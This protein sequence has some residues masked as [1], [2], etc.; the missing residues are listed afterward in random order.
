MT[1][2]F[3]ER[4]RVQRGDHQTRAT[5]WKLSQE[6]ALLSPGK[7]PLKGDT[8]AFNLV[9]GQPMADEIDVLSAVPEGRGGAE[10]GG[11]FQLSGAVQHGA[12]TTRGG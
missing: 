6:L 2:V 5:I 4:Q 9:K 10:G 7:G 8:S 3:V 11:G 12:Q 1:A